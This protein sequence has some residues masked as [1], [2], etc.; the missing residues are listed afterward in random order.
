[1]KRPAWKAVNAEIAKKKREEERRR[2]D[3]YRR[4]PFR[5]TEKRLLTIES[6]LILNGPTLEY[7]PIQDRMKIVK[8]R[9]A[10][11]IADQ[12]IAGDFINLETRL[13]MN[14]Y[15][16]GDLQEIWTGSVQV[17]RRNN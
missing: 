13:E 5:T 16:Y 3:E 1:M 12:L 11:I 6:Q 9:T 14:S 10:A 17:V 7:L 8:T 2:T 4:R 15:S